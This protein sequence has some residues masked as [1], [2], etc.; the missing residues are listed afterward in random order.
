MH[1]ADLA[2]LLGMA[3]LAICYTLQPSRAESVTAE[4]LVDGK[5]VEAVSL[6]EGQEVRFSPEGAPTVVVEVKGNQIAIVS[7]DCPDQTCVKTGF[8]HT[9]GQQSVCLPNRV[10]IRLKKSGGAD[11]TL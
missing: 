5:L 10:A 3:V 6:N 4:I 11:A 8:I 2:M 1:K 7:S 9:A